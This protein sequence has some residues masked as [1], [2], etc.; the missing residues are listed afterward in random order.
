VLD[1][2]ELTHFHV[3]LLLDADSERSTMGLFLC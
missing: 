1:S 2:I 3:E